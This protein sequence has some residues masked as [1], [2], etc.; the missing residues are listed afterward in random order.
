MI[1]VSVKGSLVG[2]QL[3]QSIGIISRTLEGSLGLGT[4]E[5]EGSF[6]DVDPSDAGHFNP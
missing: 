2:R 5:R 3:T 1:L 6:C 4:R